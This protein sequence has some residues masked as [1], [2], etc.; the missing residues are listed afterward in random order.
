MNYTFISSRLYT[1]MEERKLSE[2]ELSTQL[3]RCKSYINKIVS[4]KSLPSMK[5][6]F[7]IC[8]FFQITP[9]EFFKTQ[10]MANIKTIQKIN[11]ELEHLDSE[12]LHLI[13]ELVN[14]IHPK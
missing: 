13:L 14:R 9:V 3:G 8:D 1:L 4:G 10:S 11:S 5:G 2:Y 7:E 12:E 6:F